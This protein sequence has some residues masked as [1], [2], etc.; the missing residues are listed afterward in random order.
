ME[1]KNNKWSDVY[2]YRRMI[3]NCKVI[4]NNSCDED[5]CDL[6]DEQIADYENR[7]RELVGV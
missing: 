6:M 3:R 2:E 1:K 7:I 5:E 4:K